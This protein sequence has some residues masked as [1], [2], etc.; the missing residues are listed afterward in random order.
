MPQ[1]SLM[2]QSLR[3]ISAIGSSMKDACISS[4]LLPC[5]TSSPTSLIPS[6]ALPS[7]PSILP[8]LLDIGLDIILAERLSSRYEQTCRNLQ[9]T[10]Q[11]SLQQACCEL[12]K[13]PQH[14]A[15][16]PLPQLM[17]GAV[18]AYTA[19]YTRALAI[20]EKKAI[21]MASTLKATN[22]PCSKP[23][24][25]R[26]H[27]P[28]NTEF[29]PY[30]EKYFEYNAYPS[31]ADRAQ[32]AKKSMMEERQIAVWFQNHRRRAKQEGYAVRKANP[33]DPVPLDM[34]MKS[35]E[36]EMSTYMVPVALRQAVDD[37]EVSEQGS[38]DEDEDDDEDFD[39]EPEVVDMS[40]VLN[41]P[42][43]RHAYPLKFQESRNMAS[44]ILWTQEF[45]FPAPDW[46][47]KASKPTPKRPVVTIDECTDAFAAF[48]IW[49]TRPVLSPPFQNPTIV[50]PP[51]APLPSLVRNKFT[52]SRALATTSLNSVPAPPARKH[53]FRSPSPYAQPV[54]LAG[55]TTRRKKVAGPPRRTPKRA[56]NHR[57]VSPATS[58]TSTLRS[59]SPP[60]RFSSFAVSSP[61]SRTP[62]LESSGFSS[63]RTPSF[64]SSGFSSRSSSSSSSS[65]SGPATPTG[66]P[67]ALP[68]EIADSYLEIF[69]DSQQ[70]YASPVDEQHGKYSQQQ[71]HQFQFA[72]ERYA[73][74]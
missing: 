13:L 59:V 28:F 39:N 9:L 57:G 52:F 61:P 73:S 44:T 14:S 7:P 54:P 2:S 51:T 69:G 19:N 24:T 63:S 70:Q 5:T 42:A 4:G 29:T 1:E 62:S 50:V 60:S 47:R 32:M 36:E 6:V 48:H 56:A 10:A 64:G 20:L 33:L 74:R 66:S 16:L 25:Q 46:P 31:K 68:L 58:D 23:K 17:D 67:S 41:P 12:A 37:H 65:S 53:P 15:L 3:R 11:S 26:P 71:Q 49:D 38:D 8:Q 43:P 22:S 55:T 18:K 27:P 72:F 45:M 40:N 30:L 21:S 34:C 35:L